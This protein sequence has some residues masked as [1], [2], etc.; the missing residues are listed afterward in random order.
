MLKKIFFTVLL[1]AFMVSIGYA[2][3]QMIVGATATGPSSPLKS[4][5]I[6]THTYNCSF[7]NSTSITA[8]TV[9]LEGTID[10]K[11]T[12]DPLSTNAFDA[13]MITNKHGMRHSESKAVDYTRLNI[14]VATGSDLDADC[15]YK[16]G[17]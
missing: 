10:N 9:V 3:T 7:L 13:T 15:N 17:R 8:F 14:T 5:K 16:P 4:D 1:L 12:W 11:V 2:G 6:K